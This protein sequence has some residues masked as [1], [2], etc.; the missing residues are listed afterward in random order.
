MR[1]PVPHRRPVQQFNPLVVHVTIK[2]LKSLRRS[3]PVRPILVTHVLLVLLL[4]K[5]LAVGQEPDQLPQETET[6][7]VGV[8]EN[9]PVSFVVGEEFDGI[10]IHLWKK[11]FRGEQQ[12]YQFEETDQANA[13]SRLLSGDLAAVIGIRPTVKGLNDVL[14]TQPFLSTELALASSTRPTPMWAYARAFFSVRFAKVAASISVVLLV[15]GVF[16]W[17]AERRQNSEQFDRSAGRG[18]WDGFYWAGV[19]MTTIGY[20]D[21]VPRS[22]AGKVVAL[23]W[24]LAAIGFTS[25]LTA[26]VVSVFNSVG[27]D[28]EIER[29]PDSIRGKR[30]AVVIDSAAAT[31]L[32]GHRIATQEFEQLQGAVERLKSGEIDVVVDNAAS[33]QALPE[34]K[35]ISIRRT[36]VYPAGY[37]I[38]V[39]ADSGELHKILQREVLRQTSESDWYQTVR[40]YTRQ[41]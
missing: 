33:L 13:I 36:W 22:T 4:A 20:G 12:R 19:T 5:V 2:S 6:L 9:D 40:R 34:S 16:C 7:R 35:Q 32:K 8:L 25:I 29:F 17:L 30:V 26:S 14:Y 18:I 1:M 41:P 28:T 38:A 15:V 23:M 39:A 37:C 24:M 10:G 11:I 27:R 31:F 3:D 21:K